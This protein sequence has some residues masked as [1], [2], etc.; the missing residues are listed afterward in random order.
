MTR[1]LA[2]LL[3][4]AGPAWADT[5]AGTV[6]VVDGDTVKFGQQRV[7]IFAIDAPER[8]QSC[9]R[10]GNGVTITYACGQEARDALTA[11]I[12]G[13]PVECQRVDTDKYGRPVAMCAVAGIDLGGFMVASG[14]A[15]EAAAYTDGRYA[16]EQAE[17]KAARRGIWMG[18]FTPPDQ[19]R[20]G[21]R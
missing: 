20:K 3:L 17:A 14:W 16:D 15:I 2:L 7:R 1:T 9:T 6:T 8:Q 4:C 13:R 10:P 18:S 21:K 12:A 5:L 19:W 11:M